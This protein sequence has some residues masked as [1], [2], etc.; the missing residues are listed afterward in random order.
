MKQNIKENDMNEVV[1]RHFSK[2]GYVSFE[3]MRVGLKQIDLYFIHKHY[4]KTIAVEL[5]IRNWRQAMRQAYQN[6]FY[7][8]KSYVGLWHEFC[9][10]TIASKISKYGIGVLNIEIDNVEILE[11]P[12]HRP[13]GIYPS[14]KKIIDN[15]SSEYSS[16]FLWSNTS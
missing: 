2:N 14:M 1:I 13:I 6:T 16:E 5:K 8:Q 11:A 9:K 10:D 4:P 7:A 15:L 3:E 12:T